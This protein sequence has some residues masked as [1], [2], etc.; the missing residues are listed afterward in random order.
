[1]ICDILRLSDLESPS[2]SSEVI[3][4]VGK[5]AVDNVSEITVANL[6]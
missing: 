1:M 4:A 6:E 5:L 3:S 2:D